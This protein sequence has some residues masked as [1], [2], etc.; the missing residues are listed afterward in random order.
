[1][2]KAVS[3]GEKQKNGKRRTAGLPEEEASAEEDD[4]E[5]DWQSMMTVYLLS[6]LE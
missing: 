2:N 1:L 6:L 4:D 3:R 5:D